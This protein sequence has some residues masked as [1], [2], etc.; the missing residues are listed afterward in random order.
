MDGSVRKTVVISAV[1]LRKGGTLTIL[2]DCLEYLSRAAED[3]NLRVVALVHEKNLTPHGNIEFIEYPGTVKSW[4]RRLWCEYVTMRKVSKELSPVYLWLS[5]HDSTPNVEAERRAVYCHNAFPF[6]DWKWHQLGLNRK[7]VFFAWF[8]KFVYRKNIHK[9][10]YVIV[11]QNW[12]KEAFERRFRLD[13]DKIVVAL[14]SSEHAPIGNKPAGD[15]IFRFIFASFGDIHKNFECLCEAAGILEDKVGKDLFKVILTI[16]KEDNDYTRWLCRK[17][18]K[19]QSIDFHGFMS[20]E[21]LYGCYASADCMV[22]PSKAET[23]GL[24]ISEFA[25]SG[26]P[27]LLAD[28]PY[29]RETSAGAGKVAFF[30]PDRP[31]ELA[32]MMENVMKFPDWPGLSRVKPVE[33]VPPFSRN[34]KELFEILLNDEN[35]AIR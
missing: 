13:P 22:F 2:R 9:N 20:R 24:P 10:R 14:P 19:V 27:M 32:E 3:K 34:W 12:L 18:G 5:L 6:F 4:L 33:A 35:T 26:K 8:S 30:D 1:N 17:W 7:I 29:A 28:L 15:G 21:E 25:V 31:E 23:W 16:G 11:Q